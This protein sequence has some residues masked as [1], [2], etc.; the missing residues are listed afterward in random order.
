MFLLSVL[1]ELAVLCVVLNGETIL[2]CT[3]VAT[4]MAGV[5][6][7]NTVLQ[8]VCAEGTAGKVSVS[9][10]LVWGSRLDT[11]PFPQAPPDRLDTARLT[12]AVSFASL[13]R[14]MTTRLRTVMGPSA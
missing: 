10:C 14:R 3:Q 7:G 5:V 1:Y 12:A 4:G 8:S 6:D 13:T 2:C 9:V 11:V